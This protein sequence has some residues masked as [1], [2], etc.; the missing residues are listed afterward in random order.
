MS[1][2]TVG[3]ITGV[4]YFYLDNGKSVTLNKE[5]D[6]EKLTFYIAWLNMENPEEESIFTWLTADPTLD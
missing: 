3:D 6:I 4:E 5:A 1:I 2:G